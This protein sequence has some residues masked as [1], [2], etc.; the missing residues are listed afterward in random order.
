MR[1]TLHVPC[2]V[3]AARTEVFT[4]HTAGSHD[5]DISLSIVCFT[6]YA[7]VFLPL[8]ALSSKS[9]SHAKEHA[10]PS[11]T[12]PMHVPTDPGPERS[13]DS[14]SRRPLSHNTGP[15]RTRH[16]PRSGGTPRRR[17]RRARPSRHR[18]TPCRHRRGCRPFVGVTDMARHTDVASHPL[19]GFAHP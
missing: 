17:R 18:R 11:R 7:E 13:G 1:R 16:P 15:I 2:A 5:A 6:H 19:V 9:G 8:L 12:F 3:F 4:L 14:H 10:F